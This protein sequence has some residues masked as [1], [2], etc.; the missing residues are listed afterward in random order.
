MSNISVQIWLLVAAITV[1]LAAL[2]GYRLWAIDRLERVQRLRLEGFRGPITVIDA[3]DA[4]V[5]WYQQI[6]SLFGP[7]VGVVEQQRLQKLLAQAGIKGQ[8]SLASFI[9]IK[10]I[11]ALTFAV[12][13]WTVLETRQLFES[14]FVIRI[15]FLGIGLLLGWRFPDIVLNRLVARRRVRLEHGMPDALDLLVVCAE[16]GLSLNQAVEEISR[17][18]RLS[19]TDIADEFAITS[20]EMRITPDFGKALDN[21][22]ERTGLQDLGGLVATLKQSMKFGTPLAE[23]LRMIA[24]EMRAERH[25]R[26]EERAARLPV[27]LAVPMML[28]I[29]P[30]VMMVVAT[31]LVLRLMDTFRNIS[32]GG[33]GG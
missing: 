16:S 18:L 15:A 3:P 23:S 5:P 22:V 33:F 27:L 12:M 2:S 21:M 26:I 13:A 25:S 7:L 6:A 10:V 17:Q 8:T 31:P 19:N 20:A 32:F 11:A 29:L 14:L 28:F 4:T 30:C 9:T 24:A 1:P